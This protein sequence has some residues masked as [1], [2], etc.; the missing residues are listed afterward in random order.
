MREGVSAE[1]GA[2]AP[3]R[4]LYVASL[5][6]MAANLGALDVLHALGPEFLDALDKDGKV[7][8][9]AHALHRL[10]LD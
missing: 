7:S 10:R 9:E 5:R 6:A 3:E 8:G 4:V 1:T 2:P